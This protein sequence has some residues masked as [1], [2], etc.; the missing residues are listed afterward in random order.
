MRG[1]ESRITQYICV[2]SPNFSD[3]KY[4]PCAVYGFSAALFIYFVLCDQRMR[5]LT[6]GGGDSVRPHSKQ[7]SMGTFLINARNTLEGID[8][9][10]RE[11]GTNVF[12][13]KFS[14]TFWI[15][16]LP[17]LERKTFSIKTISD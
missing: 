5:E 4:N 11:A 12:V 13:K 2:W 10:Y 16:V 6:L 1:Y 15:L 3:I 7:I 9:L 17:G 8:A 14:T